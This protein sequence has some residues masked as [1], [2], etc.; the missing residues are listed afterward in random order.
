MQEVSK[1]GMSTR[2]LTIVA[3]LGAIS[4]VLGFTPIG[5][6][7]IGAISIT[8]MHIP[9]IVGAILEGPLVGM[10]A[11]LLFGVISIVRAFMMPTPTSFLFWNPIISILP[12]VLIG[13]VTYKSYSILVRRMDKTN[14]AIGVSACMGTITNTVGVLGLGYLLYS[15]ALSEKLNMSVQAVKLL[16]VG[17]VVQN[18]IP[19]IILSVIV[20]LGV[21]KAMM[22]ARKSN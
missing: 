7:Q 10:M 17:I 16:F 4:A 21:C 9:V 6:I 15:S 20:A 1:R 11:G 14:L 12:R 8:T 18:G 22:R 13:Y 19:E 3:V 5:F 2:Q